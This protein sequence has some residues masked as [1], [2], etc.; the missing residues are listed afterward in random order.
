MSVDST[1]TAEIVG[2]LL[3][4]GLVLGFVY[5][6]NRSRI[7]QRNE[8]LRLETTQ[9]PGERAFNEIQIVRAGVD[10]L[11]RQGW[12]VEGVRRVLG[13]AEGAEQRGDHSGA[14]RTAE[15]AREMLYRL[16]GNTAGVNPSGAVPGPVLPTTPGAIATTSGRDPSSGAAA[17]RPGLLSN[18]AKEADASETATRT[19][20]PAYQLEA[21]FALNALAL[22]LEHHPSSNG[23]G[24]RSGVEDLQKQ[25]QVAYGAAQYSEAWRL[26]LRAR[27]MLG[28]SVE[29]ISFSAASEGAPKSPSPSLPGTDRIALPPST[30]EPCAQCG[31]PLRSDDKFCRSCGAPAAR[32]RCARCGTANESADRFC[33]VCGAPLG[34]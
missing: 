30:P 22:D 29:A 24:A 12:Q 13:E 15:T 14:L 16:R 10:H 8:R 18:L 1:Q 26:A 20:P 7:R 28:G 23:A 2:A 17:D 25:A 9:S 5:W 11:G 32:R 19:K 31:K 33:G 4:S 6:L 3:A 34:D 27:R 21:R